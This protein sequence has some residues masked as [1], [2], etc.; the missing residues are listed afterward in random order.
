[1]LIWDSFRYDLNRGFFTSG[2]G[3]L[4]RQ[5]PVRQQGW[6]HRSFCGWLHRPQAELVRH[7]LVETEY[8]ATD[9]FEGDPDRRGE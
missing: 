9:W 6:R 4:W 1:M 3:H 5:D 7:R 2:L 8:E